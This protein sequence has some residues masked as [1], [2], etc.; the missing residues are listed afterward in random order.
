[1]SKINKL[2]AN[3]LLLN[4]QARQYHLAL[5]GTSKDLYAVF[6]LDLFKE[7]EVMTYEAAEVFKVEASRLR[8]PY[9]IAPIA[10]EMAIY[11]ADSVA[12]KE[13]IIN[14]FLGVK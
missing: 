3:V 13:Q 8:Y 9:L 2:E 11:V 5:S 4:E 12:T 1:M 14:F 7:T 6:C 10:P